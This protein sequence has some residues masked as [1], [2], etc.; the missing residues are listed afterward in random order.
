MSHSL[1]VR[2]FEEENRVTQSESTYIWR[3]ED[4]WCQ[5]N[6]PVSIWPIGL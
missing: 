1:E 4:I 3:L 5:R 2:I 6:Y